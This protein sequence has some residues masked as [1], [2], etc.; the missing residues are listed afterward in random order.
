MKP[1]QV[2]ALLCVITLP[3]MS[4]YDRQL[5]DNEHTIEVA[6]GDKDVSV[7]AQSKTR[8][9]IIVEEDKLSPCHTFV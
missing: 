4:A 1:L 7:P 3:W 2:I 5:Q 6:V 8:D 9:V